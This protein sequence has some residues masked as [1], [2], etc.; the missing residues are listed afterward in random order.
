MKYIRLFETEA[1]YEAEKS[2]L[3]RPNVCYIEESDRVVYK[4]NDIISFVDSATKAALVAAYDTDNDGEV[5][6]SEA[7]AATTWDVTLSSATTTDMS[8]VKYFYNVIFSSL[9][10]QN[11]VVCKIFDFTGC[12]FG[13]RI[14]MVGMFKGCKVA[15]E[16]R[17]V[18]CDFSGVTRISEMFNSSGT[19]PL[20]VDFTNAVLPSFSNLTNH[21]ILFGSQSTI[22]F[23]MDGCSEDSVNT[24]K[25][26]CQE[27]TNVANARISINNT[28]YRYSEGA[29]VVVE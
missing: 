6:Y 19:T 22:T 3:P 5:S 28:V 27:T 9:S 4:A 25:L 24:I 1:Q 21:G 8:F 11:Y 14:S 20:V 15:Q 26:L 12:Q 29:W 7:A 23:I 10:C 13:S 17:L 16:I 2:S 18:G